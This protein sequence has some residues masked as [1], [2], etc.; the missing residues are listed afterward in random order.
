MLF[1]SALYLQYIRGQ[2][3][4]IADALSCDHHLNILKLTKT[5]LRLYP[6]QTSHNFQ[7]LPLPEKITSWLQLIRKS[8]LLP[9]PCKSKLGA[10][11]DGEDSWETWESKMSGCLNFNKTNTT[12]P[13]PHLQA[14]VEGMKMVQQESQYCTEKIV[15]STITNIRSSFRT[16]LRPD[17]ALD[18]D[19]KTSLFLT[20]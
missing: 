6:D 2:H 13:Y 19:M 11:I 10:L 8:E 20:R 5:F 4:I 7:I 9:R 15:K 14:V 1:D 18:P 12:T 17:P 3:N 16:N